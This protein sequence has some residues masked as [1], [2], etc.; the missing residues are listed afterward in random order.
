MSRGP[1]IEHQPPGALPDHDAVGMPEKRRRP[2]GV[3]VGL[4]VLAIAGLGTGAGV[5]VANV[6]G[7]A[8]SVP[9]AASSAPAA[10]VSPTPESAGGPA[11]TAVEAEIDTALTATEWP[12]LTPSIDELYSTDRV[13]ARAFSCSETA[14]CAADSVGLPDLV[15]FGDSTGGALLPTV[16]AAV[17]KEYAITDMSLAN[18]ESIDIAVRFP[19]AE[20]EQRCLQHRADSI[21]AIQAMKP[22]VVVIINSH[23]SAVLLK[24]LAQGDAR[25]AEWSSAMQRTVDQV[26]AAAGRVVIVSPPPRGILLEECATPLS[27]PEDC[28]STMPDVDLRLSTVE[29]E[30]TGANVAHL[31][32]SR[33]YCDADGRCPSFAAGMPIKVDGVHMT[34][35]W[36]MHLGPV[37]AEELDAAVGA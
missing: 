9:P 19:D 8:E 25:D 11:L 35:Q 32:T 17:G 36:A 10:S 29:S 21:A 23:G 33:W 18:C 16:H 14:T 20:F 31:D 27:T 12:V 3:L 22:A 24:S 30:A 5:V 7:E 26:S 2:K 34:K 13:T 37:F 1:P 6:V 28:V 4:A 15:V